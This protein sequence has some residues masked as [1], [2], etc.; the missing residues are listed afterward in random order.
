M[1][2]KTVN[3]LAKS[4]AEINITA[5]WEDVA[6]IWQRVVARLTQEAELPGFRKGMA[7]SQMIEQQLGAKIQDEFLKEAM[8]NLLVNVLQELKIVPIDYPKY[9]LVSFAKGQPL[10]F[11]ATVTQKPQIKVEDY[12]TI[13]VNRPAQKPVTDEDIKRVVDDLYKRFKSRLAVNQISNSPQANSSSGPT[14]ASSITS[15]S[16]D[17]NKPQP[18]GL[19]DASGKPLTSSPV[20]DEPNDEFAK[21]L[22]AQNLADLKTRIRSDLE[23]ENK[24]ENELDYEEAILQEV[25]KHTQVDLPEVLIEDE[26]NRMMVSIQKRVSEM[27]LMLEDY[28]KSQNETVE[29]LR[30]K[31]RPQAEQ[32]VRMELGLAE[33]ARLENIDITDQEVQVEVDKIQDGRLKAQ[34]EA[35]EPRLQLRHSLRQIK[36]LEFLKGLVKTA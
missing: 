16:I 5:A 10:Q 2:N 27:G 11:K 28:L 12:K 24:R 1:I 15:G 29:G 25:E 4:Q 3:N 7:P 13:S 8:P 19:V 14:Q 23:A 6:A 36:T 30:T 17:F 32:N 35:A 18:N 31:W 9:Q 33:I 20:A 26:L 34:F 21:S 22:G